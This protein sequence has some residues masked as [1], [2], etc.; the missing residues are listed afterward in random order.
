[1]SFR[2]D[3]PEWMAKAMFPLHISDFSF[4]ATHAKTGIEFY[5]RV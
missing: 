3:F 4:G 5:V 1:M 2:S